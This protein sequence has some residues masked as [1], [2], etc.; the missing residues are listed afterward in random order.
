M[1]GPTIS[2]RETL[3]RVTFDPSTGNRA[4]VVD[5][6]TT[7]RFQ[8]R[9][10]RPGVFNLFWKRADGTGDTQ[11][12]TDSP[13]PQLPSSW[14][15]TRPILAFYDGAPPNPQRVMLWSWMVTKRQVG[16]SSTG[17]VR[18]G[19]LSQRRTDVLSRRQL[20][21]L[22]VRQVGTAGVYVRPFPGP[23]RRGAR[24]SVAA[25]TTRSGQSV[26]GNCYAAP[27]LRP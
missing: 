8:R 17:R 10:S 16:T 5:G 1:C 7:N 23:W 25:P 9:V 18:I 19:S 15:P 20:A 4:R 2:G 6:L 27:S 26:V 14:H 21:G 22:R 11:R 3:G 13:L 24:I 12:L